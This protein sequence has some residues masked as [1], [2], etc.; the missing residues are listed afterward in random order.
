MINP[1]RKKLK[2]SAQYGEKGGQQLARHVRAKDG[3]LEVE[4]KDEKYRLRGV[5]RGHVLHGPMRPLKRYIKVFITESLIK[6]LPH[7][8][9]DDQLCEPVREIARVFDL[10]IEAEDEF[11][12]KRQIGQMKKGVCGLM[13]ED[14]AWR[15]RVQWAL[16]KLNIKKVKLNKADKYYF[17]AKSFKVD[18]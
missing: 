3:S 11:E 7:L 16:E 4:I 6:C 5:P 13:Q 1:F 8:L 12:M 17:R 9:P 15:F 10:V 14:D 18:T 2:E